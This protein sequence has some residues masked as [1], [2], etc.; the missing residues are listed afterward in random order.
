M[1]VEHHHR[2]RRHFL[3]LHSRFFLSASLSIF[4]TIKRVKDSSEERQCSSWL[5][6]ATTGTEGK[7]V[8]L[9]GTVPKPILRCAHATVSIVKN[10]ED[11]GCKVTSWKIGKGVERK[12]EIKWNESNG[13]LPSWKI[14][15]SL[16]SKF[17]RRS[18]CARGGLLRAAC[19]RYSAVSS[20][21]VKKK[22]GKGQELLFFFR[23]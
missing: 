15:D 21:L 17:C 12:R 10:R 8:H 6:L 5:L 23:F 18:L 20:C 4:H 14:S 1:A 16:R 9:L 7:V 22:G 3:S 11:G 13:F 2:Q 19:G